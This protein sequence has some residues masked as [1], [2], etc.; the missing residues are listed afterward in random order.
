MNIK[1]TYISKD[2]LELFYTRIGK[3]NLKTA[4]LV[5]KRSRVSDPFSEPEILGS[6]HGFV[7]APTLTGDG[8]TLYFHKREGSKFVLFKVHR[9]T[10]P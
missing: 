5:A 8:K 2:G 1:P 10:R 4:I 9:E 3:T 6:I 7:E